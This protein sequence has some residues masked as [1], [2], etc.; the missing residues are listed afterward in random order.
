MITSPIYNHQDKLKSLEIAKE[1][2]EV[3]NKE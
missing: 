2:M 3:L 1:V